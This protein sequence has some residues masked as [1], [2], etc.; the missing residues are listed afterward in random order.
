M[1]RPRKHTGVDPGSRIPREA[2]GHHPQ[3][4]HSF[5]PCANQIPPSVRAV[6]WEIRKHYV[7]SIGYP[8]ADERTKRVG[9][10][11]AETLPHD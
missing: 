3:F 7:S 11:T 6:M 8:E 2:G 9:S 4:I 5:T 10:V 1:L